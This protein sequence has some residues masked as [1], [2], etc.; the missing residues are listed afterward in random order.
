MMPPNP[1]LF[2]ESDVDSKAIKRRMDGWVEKT[3][4]VLN[5]MNQSGYNQTAK[6]EAHEMVERIA[7]RMS[8]L[9]VA[10]RHL[11][12]E[13]LLSSF[14]YHLTKSDLKRKH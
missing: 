5:K 10:Y 9:I 12:D 14:I 1:A 6:R 7:E 8:G 13:H 2:S 3:L 11:V 4:Y